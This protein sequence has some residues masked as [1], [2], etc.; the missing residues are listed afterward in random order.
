MTIAD[1]EHSV[2]LQQHRGLRRCVQSPG[3]AERLKE[4]QVVLARGR[5]A[6]LVLWTRAKPDRVRST[7]NGG[8]TM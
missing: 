5:F 8:R 2:D 4:A 6:Q 7:G 1:L 3:E